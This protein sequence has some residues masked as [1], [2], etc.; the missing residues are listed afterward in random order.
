MSKSLTS[1][2]L[3]KLE[4]MNRQLNTIVNKAT[5]SSIASAKNKKRRSSAGSSGKKRT[6]SRSRSRKH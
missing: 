1:A 6:R 3:K 5:A 4:S 2:D